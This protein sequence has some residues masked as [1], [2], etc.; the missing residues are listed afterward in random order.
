V[1]KVTSIALIAL[2]LLNVMGYYG[3][4]IGLD[5]QHDRRMSEK[6]D[7]DIYNAS[8]AITI[9]IPVNIPYATES[10]DFQRVD[11]E[12][13]YMG[14]TY[15]MVKQRILNGTLYLVCV[16]DVK[17]GRIAQALKDYV[18]TFSDKPADAKSQSKTQITLIKD[19]IPSTCSVSNSSE[20]WTS[21]VRNQ[22]EPAVFIDSFCASIVHPPERG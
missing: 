1:K 6:L 4:F 10:P 13:E 15:R 21:V 7:T 20:G 14:E 8:E 5:Y 22:T 3:V 11:G 19:Y 12:F 17:G 2:V 16:K 9:E 18:K